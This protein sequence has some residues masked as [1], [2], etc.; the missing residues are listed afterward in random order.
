L[1]E[2]CALV[3]AAGRGSRAGLAYPKTLFPLQGR[4]ILLRICDVLRPYDAQPTVVVSSTGEE[5]IRECLAGASVAAHLVRQPAPT[6]MGDAVL[7]FAESPAFAAAEHVLLIWGD[8]PFIQPK[9]VAAMMHAHH[10]HDNDFTLVTRPTERPYTLVERT[11][12]G[13]VARVLET[14]EEGIVPPSWGERD[15]GLFVFR[16]DVVMPL[17]REKL[18]DKR[19][20]STGEHGFL[21]IVGH[22]VERAFRVEA[23]PIAAEIETVSLNKVQDVVGLVS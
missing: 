22:L 11:I 19:G 8:V 16:R 1:A 6:G 17:L 14:R 10:A 2:T 12:G 9:T 4:P 20:K 21:Y 5:P 7:R 23:L 13:A 15:V 18:P 3:A